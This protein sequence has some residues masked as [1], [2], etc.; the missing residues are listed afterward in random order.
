MAF[1]FARR[2]E[3]QKAADMDRDIWSLLGLTQANAADLADG[4]DENER[5]PAPFKMAF[6]GPGG[7]EAETTSVGG[8]REQD[9]VERIVNSILMCAIKDGA[10]DIHIEPLA[11]SVSV[12]YRVKGELRD[13]LRLPGLVHKP[14]VARIKKLG[15]LDTAGGEAQWGVIR[16]RLDERD[17]DLQIS[18]QPTE[19]GERVMMRVSGSR[20]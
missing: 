5:Q 18:T 20:L 10:S 12:R 11:K 3:K 16:L 8:W 2:S 4:I 14:L 1:L 9:P 13:H 6:P 7:S 19:H 15:K 17:Y